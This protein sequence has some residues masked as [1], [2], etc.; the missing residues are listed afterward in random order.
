[1]PTTSLTQRAVDVL[2][3]PKSGRV[4]YFD[5]TLPGFGL[6]LSEGGRKTWFVMY[7]VGGKKVRETLGTLAS[8]PRV[9]DARE[10]AQESMRQAQKGIHPIKARKSAEDHPP[11]L[12]FDAAADRYLAQHVERNTRPATTKEIRRILDHD[13]RPKWG[14]RPI[15]EI[16]RSDVNDLLDQIADRGALVQANR[17]LAQLKTMFSWALDRELVD[18]DPTARVRKRV[19]ETARDRA[20]TSEEIRL[21]WAACD[22][23]GWPFG[24]L[25]KLLLVTA[26]RRDEVGSMEWPELD[27]G[28]RLWTIPRQKAKN[29]RAHEV[30]LSELAIAIIESLPRI[31]VPADKEEGRVTVPEFVFT[32]TGV[33]AVSGFSKA[34]VSLDKHMVAGLRDELKEAG[35]G[36]EGAPIEDWILHDLR[37]TAATG[38]AA[39]NIMPHVVDRILNHVSGTIRGVAAVYNRHAYLDER[40][41]ALEAWG[42]HVQT[43]VS[44]APSNVVSLITAR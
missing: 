12:R 8:I 44:G 29:D 10:R 7:R 30:H 26:Q 37:R 18:A 42:R 11:A 36:A 28:K 34:K 2:K 23:I 9:A 32:T 35:K 39:L 19:K 14:A 17:T 1:M 43:V 25:F 20:L 21:V 41:V 6:R 40:K 31:A 4:E 38:M 16:S 22:R 13:V 15:T 33:S 3:P 5:R 27:L 24:P